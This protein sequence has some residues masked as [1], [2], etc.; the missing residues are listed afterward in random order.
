MFSGI[1]ETLGI[2]R[3][4]NHS[5]DSVI[6]HIE[7]LAPF[8]DLHIGD[9]IS[10]NGACL[11]AT[12]LLP[13]MFSVTAV[14][15]TLRLTNLGDLKVNSEV[16]LERSLLVG[17]RNGGHHVQ[18]HVDT[19]GHILEIT[20]DGQDAIIVKI[21]IAPILSKYI[22]NKGYISLDG[23]SITVLQAAQDWFTVMFVPHTRAVTIVKN[24]RV[25]TKV[26][27]EVDMFGKYIEKLFGVYKNAV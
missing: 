8:N 21:S 3:Y 10:I 25:G 2:I 22:V 11:T 6:F 26:N 7:S 24:Y 1:V 15:E 19:L 9:S 4:L 20:A 17:S 23:M 13:N 5:P 27:I 16:N 12:E 18:G 14:P